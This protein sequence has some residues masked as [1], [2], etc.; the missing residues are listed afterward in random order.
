MTPICAR[1]WPDSLDRYL[2]RRCA[3]LMGTYLGWIDDIED[4]LEDLAAGR[5]SLVSVDLYMYS[6]RPMNLAP[7]EMIRKLAETLG[8]DGV[9]QTIIKTGLDHYDELVR[10]LAAI[11]IDHE[12]ILQLVEDATFAGLRE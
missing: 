5:W 8:S 9:R 1:G 7:A 11:G 10:G 12:P 3:Y 2:Y 4:L 6:G